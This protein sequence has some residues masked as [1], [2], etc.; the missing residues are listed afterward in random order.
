MH[1]EVMITYLLQG[2]MVYQATM[3]C[4]K[5]CQEEL[6]G[7]CCRGFYHQSQPAPA[8]WAAMQWQCGHCTE[9]P[10]VQISVL[11]S[12]LPT[13]PLTALIPHSC[14]TGPHSHCCLQIQES[15]SRF[16]NQACKRC[17]KHD[18]DLFSSQPRSIEILIFNDKGMFSTDEDFQKYAEISGNYIYM[19][20]SNL[21][22]VGSLHQ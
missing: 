20:C 22:L 10:P 9:T 17:R 14:D 8:S 13:P 5:Q 18:D 6:P 2:N 11:P 21:I 4:M 16:Q 1:D 19:T 3:R 12:Y 7:Q 15:R